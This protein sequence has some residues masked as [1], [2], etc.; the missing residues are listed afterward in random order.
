M[1]LREVVSKISLAGSPYD[2]V[3]ALLDTIPNPVEPHVNGFGSP[4]LG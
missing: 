1:R 2:R 4:N 3:L